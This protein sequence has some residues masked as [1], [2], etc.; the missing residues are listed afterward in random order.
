MKQPN[1]W[2]WVP[3]LYLAE[4]LPN[5]LVTSMS[6]TLFT[7]LGMENGK[8]ALFTSL[9]AYPWIV[10]P[11][12]SPFVDSIRTKRWWVLAMQFPMALTVLLLALLAPKGYTTIALILFTVTAFCSATHDIAADGYYMLAL[13][14][15]Q[16]SR[17]IGIRS[18][19]YKVANVLCQFVILKIIDYLQH[20]NVDNATSWTIGLLICSALLACIAIAHVWSMPK[21]EAQP[22]EHKSIAAIGREVLQPFAEFFRKPGIGLAICFMLLCRLPEALLLKLRDPFFLGS[23]ADGGMG[24]T[25]G[26]IADLNIVGLVLMVLGGLAGGWWAEKAGLKKVIM[27]MILCIALPCIVYVYFAQY[28]PT[29]FWIMSICVGFEQLGYGLGYT[30]CMLYMIRVADGAHKTALFSICTAFMYLG[31]VLPGMIAGYIQEATG[32][33]WFFWIVMLCCVPSILVTEVVRR[34]LD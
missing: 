32:Y 11:L 4:G 18:A 29:S 12:W 19:F 22:S 3:T 30:A 21:V 33:L 10:K 31:Y 17:F 23:T 1:P 25:L 13:D 16:Q 27:P 24:L 7:Q 6:I 15:K 28:Q 20:S 9:I 8:I 34:R 26:N 14:E 5:F 2:A